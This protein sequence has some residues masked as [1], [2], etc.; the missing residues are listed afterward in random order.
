MDHSVSVLCELENVSSEVNALRVH[1]EQV[2]HDILSSHASKEN[3]HERL[4]SHE[5]MS[6]DIPHTLQGEI[7]KKLRHHHIFFT[8]ESLQSSV[9]EL[10]N[11]LTL[12]MRRLPT[13]QQEVDALDKLLQS[14]K[15]RSAQEIRELHSILNDLQHEHT[16]LQPGV[17]R[18]GSEGPTSYPIP[19][20]PRLVSECVQREMEEFRRQRCLDEDSLMKRIH[21]L[22]DEIR[23]ITCGCSPRLESVSLAV[24]ENRVL[25]LEQLVELGVTREGERRFSLQIE[26]QSVETRVTLFVGQANEHEELKLCLDCL[27]NPLRCGVFPHPA[28]DSTLILRRFGDL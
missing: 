10:S 5:E 18:L 20:L 14:E 6:V 19:D 23:Q 21:S 24:I 7:Q 26:L 15:H 3:A 22:E 13:I 16:R 2:A 4:D 9:G 28:F 8:L 12:Q 25:V 11:R 1:S 27:E 17:C